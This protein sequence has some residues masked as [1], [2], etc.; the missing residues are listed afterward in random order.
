MSA[1]CLKVL[2][3]PGYT[4]KE[5]RPA[6]GL[7]STE[8]VLLCTAHNKRFVNCSCAI[9]KVRGTSK[10]IFLPYNFFVLDTIFCPVYW[11]ARL[12]SI[13]LNVWL[14]QFFSCHKTLKL[15]REKGQK[16]VLG[17]AQPSQPASAVQRT[18]LISR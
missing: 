3:K 18:S 2:E 1:L 10:D 17:A 8:T 6:L 14:Q 15:I 11:W 12:V 4:T 5:P 7:L 13:H 9:I 16:Q